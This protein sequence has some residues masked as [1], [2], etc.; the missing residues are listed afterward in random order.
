MKKEQLQKPQFS[1]TVL[2]QEIVNVLK[3]PPFNDTMTLMSFNDKKEFEL[4][5]LIMKVLGMID[6]ELKIG[7]N[8]N[9]NSI[10]KKLLDFLKTVGFPYS[11]DKQLEDDLTRA[12]KRLLVQII[13]FTL[14]K[15]NELKK[16]YYLSKY[17]NNITV[18]D[19]L[20]GDE[21][22]SEL[23]NQYRELQSEFQATYQLAEEKRSSKPQLKDLKE[24][25]KKLQTDKLQ[26][27]SSIA[28]F[29]K[30]YSSKPEFKSLFESTSKLRKEQEEDSN[31]ERQLT[32]LQYEYEEV[33]SK[34]MIA[35][36]RL[37]D[38][39]NS[40]REDISA[41]DML[42]NLMNQR[43]KNREILSNITE[44]ELIDKKSKL[45]SLEEILMMPEV[46]FDMLN[47]SRQEK[48]RLEG[49]IER[50]EQK[51]KTSPQ[52]S[53]ELE[54]YLNNIKLSTQQKDQALKMLDKLEKEKQMLDNKYSELEKRF[55]NKHGYR[56]IRKGD[57]LQQIENI[58]EKKEIYNKCTKALDAIKTEGLLLDR[59]INILK[60]KVDDFEEIVSRIEE[61]YGVIAGV[62]STKR[63][64]ED[65]ARRKKDIDNT[66]EMTLEEYSKLI[67]ELK[68][69]IESTYSLYSPL[70][71]HK[72]RLQKEFESLQP[73]YQRKKN[74]Y[75]SS[76][77]DNLKVFNKIKEE[78]SSL[79]ADFAKY[80]ND[81]YTYNIQLKLLEDQ[82]KRYESESSF[83]KD[84]KLNKEHK[85]FT[86]YYR[87]VMN[88]HAKTIKDLDIK[89]NAV[90]ETSQDNYRQIKYFKDLK[91]LLDAKKANLMSSDSKK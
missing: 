80:Q 88:Y 38:C 75:E 73:E 66:K 65:L 46:T 54:I 21:D 35:K 56:Y 78:Y 79:E 36:Q 34:L 76:M 70:I 48:K 18:S 50:L 33:E 69:K 61:K 51:V 40:L 83:Q 44:I 41:L 43:D 32:K 62:G 77:S 5:E 55:E 31:L 30:N 7:K 11:N 57:L 89:K 72:E 45:K 27:N 58:K 17:L 71:D 28:N 49:D 20:M 91:K 24:E 29:K 53:T 14:T 15:L 67:S 42:E 2:V 74:A 64:L 12:D 13:H 84:K 16:K 52:R 85:S 60:A 6:D 23:M 39:R 63:E 4:L 25:I 68:K 37:V 10:L 19:E 47:T 59:T 90:R 26:L 82:L 81:Y 22:I 86:D 1:S 3:L 8:E 9:E 87:E